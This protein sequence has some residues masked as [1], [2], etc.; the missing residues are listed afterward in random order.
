MVIQGFTLTAAGKIQF[1]PGQKSVTVNKGESVQFVLTNDSGLTLLDWG[2]YFNNPF[3]ISNSLRYSF[4]DLQPDGN[5]FVAEKT[6]SDDT[7]D[8]RVPMY[9]A[10]A[11]YVKVQNASGVQTIYQRDPEIIVNGGEVDD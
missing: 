7:A 8:T 10:Y 5:V 1:A 11:I 2:L 4:G 9:N 6:V 3:D